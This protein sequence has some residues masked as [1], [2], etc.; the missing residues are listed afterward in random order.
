M[1]P[2]GSSHVHIH[3]HVHMNGLDGGVGKVDVVVSGSTPEERMLATLMSADQG[4]DDAQ[5]LGPAF[6][7]AVHLVQKGFVGR[8]LMMMMSSSRD[9]H[10]M[11]SMP[12]SRSIWVVF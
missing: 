1:S 3:V 10:T 6:A 7:W 11:R 4:Q 2:A 5:G 9:D 12:T 8:K